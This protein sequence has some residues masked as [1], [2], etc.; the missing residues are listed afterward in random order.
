MYQI[1]R[2][3]HQQT[4]REQR[5]VAH[6]VGELAEWIGRG[7]IHQVHGDHDEGNES[8]GNPALLGAQDEKGFAKAR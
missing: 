7:R 6:A 1:G 8:D 3:Q 5:L 2:N 4:E